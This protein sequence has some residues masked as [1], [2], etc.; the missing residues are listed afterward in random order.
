MAPSLQDRADVAV[1]NEIGIIE[2]L[3]RLSV[4]AHLPPGM[5][6]AHVEL[7][8]RFH[9]DGDGQTPAE[10]ARAMLMS[11]AAMTSALQKMEAM[12]F[13]V[14]LSDVTDR[15]K[16]R[17]RLARGGREAH[18]ELLKGMKWKMDALREG[19]TDAEFRQALPFLRSLR[20]FLEDVIGADGPEAAS[21]R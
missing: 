4:T 17:V 12:G 9:R 20:L 10:L 3:T 15:R 1:F 8:M 16:K 6:Y 13:I 11:K 7:L 18:A 19:F 14:L 2:H 5:T 21:L